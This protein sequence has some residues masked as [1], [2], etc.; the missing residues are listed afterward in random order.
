M[1]NQPVDNGKM[2]LTKVAKRIK[3]CDRMVSDQTINLCIN[4]R[5]FCDDLLFFRNFEYAGRQRIADLDSKERDSPNLG[6]Q[7]GRKER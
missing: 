7:Y 5:F 3:I 4:M 1:T 6:H 2:E